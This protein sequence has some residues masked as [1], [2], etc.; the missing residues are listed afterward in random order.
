MTIERFAELT[1]IWWPSV[2]GWRDSIRR[3]LRSWAE[4]AGPELDASIKVE[5]IESA[6]KLVEQGLG[7]RYVLRTVYESASFPAG[8]EV[9][10]FTRRIHDSYAFI[11]RKDHALSPAT[12]ELITMARATHGRLRTC[13]AP[14]RGQVALCESTW[15]RCRNPPDCVSGESWCYGQRALGR[16]LSP[17]GEVPCEHDQQ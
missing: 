6:L 1:M 14:G 17:N 7:N 13:C 12:S 2:S 8:L 9:A 11:R 10:P 15:A 5:Q 16:C 3:Q 4:D